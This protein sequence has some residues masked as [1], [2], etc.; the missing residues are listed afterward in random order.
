M[1]SQADIEAAAQRI[2]PHIRRTPVIALDVDF[3]GTPAPVI[4]KLELL[5]HTGSFKPRGAFNRMLTHALPPSGVIAASGGN[6][7]LAV[8]YAA[9]RLGTTAEVFVP[10]NCPEIK[11]QKLRSFG[12]AV[13]LIEGLYDDAYVACAARA[14]ESG[15]LLVHPFDQ[16]E[17]ATGQGTMAME[18]D[19]QVAGV[20]TVLIACG[21]GG[22]AAGAAAWFGPRAKVVVVEP[23]TS[24]CFSAAVEAGEPVA[25]E[26]T[27]VANDSL[28][29][30]KV[31][32]LAFDILKASDAASVVVTDD[33]IIEA[34]HHIWTHLQLVAEPGGATA[35][36]ALLS[37]A[38]SPG[39]DETVV[40]AICGANTDPANVV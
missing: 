21:G 34:Q 13:H 24:R 37:G 26:R 7:G 32:E 25:V 2:A 28:G 33:A 30:A 3:F 22:F 31:G 35:A 23:Q 6:H 39:P 29:A 1:I 9:R 4:A 12:A 14:E 18:V 38:Y 40:V 36:A 19:D 11:V 5:Q 10:A 8:A 27:S 17:V 15:A 20:D 16:I